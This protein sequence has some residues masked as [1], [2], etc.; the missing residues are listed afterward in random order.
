MQTSNSSNNEANQKG[1]GQG[2]FTIRPVK[3]KTSDDG[4]TSRTRDISDTSDMTSTDTSS[5]PNRNHDAFS[6][7]SNNQVRI[8]TLRGSSSSTNNQEAQPQPQQQHEE[9]KTRIS[10]E[11]HPSL[12]LDDLI[13]GGLFGGDGD[14]EA[15]IEDFFDLLEDNLWAHSNS[16]CGVADADVEGTNFSCYEMMIEEDM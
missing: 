16:P 6:Y 14:D 3:T 12:I 13:L 9:R 8:E 4:G 7:Y 15:G 10:F 11:L 5:H 1:Q 2:R